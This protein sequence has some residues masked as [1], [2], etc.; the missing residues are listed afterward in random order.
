LEKTMNLP[1]KAKKLPV[2]SPLEFVG[3]QIQ[4][5]EF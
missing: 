1:L 5:L 2:E 4:I 3:W